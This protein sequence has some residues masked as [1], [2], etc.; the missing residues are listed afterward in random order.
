MVLLA[1][2]IYRDKGGQQSAMVVRDACPECGSQQFK[3]NGHIHNGKQNH[4]C[5][6]CGRQFVLHAETRVIVEEQRTLVERLLREKISLRGI[7]RTVGVSIRWLMDFMVTCFEALPDHLHVQPVASP[8]DVIIGRLEVEADE[9]CSFVK[10]K[11]NKQWVWLAMDKQTRHIIAFH[12]GDR[13]RDS[14]KQLWASLPEVYCTQATFY[15]DQYEVYKGVIPAAQHKAITKK[16]R[17]TNYIERFNNT[18]RQRV[19]RLVRDTLAFSKK[20]ANH[21]G[22]IKYFICHY[23]LTRASALPV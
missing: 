13:S 15:T 16:A 2:N 23:N 5:K 12:V 9:M 18:L 14:A 1:R 11:A 8:R 7:C 19:S 6:A 4:Q 10:Q 21:I 20:L 22:A 17:K 3:K